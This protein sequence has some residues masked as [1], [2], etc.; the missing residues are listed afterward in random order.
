MCVI[1]I[2]IHADNKIEIYS[3]NLNYISYLNKYD[4]NIYTFKNNDE[5]KENILFIKNEKLYL[6]F[7]KFD[8][9]GTFV[10]VYEAPKKTKND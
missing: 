3:K 6:I 2:N 5:N 1:N 10:K 9:I 8:D 7:N 4:T